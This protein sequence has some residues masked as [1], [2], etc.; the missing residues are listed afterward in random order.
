[1]FVYNLFD[2]VG[3]YGL[4]TLAGY[5]MPNPLYVKF[6]RFGWVGFYGLSTIEGYLMPNPL[7]TYILNI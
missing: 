2:L 3:F 7:F 1:M 6:I 4:S 5:L